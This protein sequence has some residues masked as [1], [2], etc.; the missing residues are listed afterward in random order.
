LVI[1]RS[2][3]NLSGVGVRVCWICGS[4]RDA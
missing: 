4:L 2:E 3:R 1:G